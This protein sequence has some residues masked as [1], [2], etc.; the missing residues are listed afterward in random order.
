MNPFERKEKKSYEHFQPFSF[1]FLSLPFFF[2]NP[3]LS[4]ILLYHFFSF[5][6]FPN[7]P[8]TLTQEEVEKQD[9]VMT[10]LF[11]TFASFFPFP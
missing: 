1:S 3:Y 2:S 6:S 7:F 11:F 10:S 9:D 5:A 4:F 8:R